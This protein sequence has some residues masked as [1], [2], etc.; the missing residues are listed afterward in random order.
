MA[1]IKKSENVYRYYDEAKKLYETTFG[2]FDSVETAYFYLRWLDGE[3]P[4]YTKEK[5]GLIYDVFSISDIEKKILKLTK[6]YYV[7]VHHPEG[8][9]TGFEAPRRIYDRI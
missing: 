1:G 7:L 4:E 2:K 8:Y 6:D 9:I 3:I 5:G